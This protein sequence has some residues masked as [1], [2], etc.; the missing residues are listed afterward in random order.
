MVT[1]KELYTTTIAGL[2]GYYGHEQ[3]ARILNVNLSDLYRW[4]A[5]TA[6]PPS[7]VFFR[8]IDMTNDE[9]VH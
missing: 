3:L 9:N 4:A 7:G 6:R 5:G 2:L 1:D 8:I